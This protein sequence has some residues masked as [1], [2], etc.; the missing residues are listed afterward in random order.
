MRVGLAAAVVAAAGRVEWRS[1]AHVWRSGG[2]R[3]RVM[4]LLRPP[5]LGSMETQYMLCMY[6]GHVSTRNAGGIGSP[7]A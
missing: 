4:A 3:V 1:R 6:M 5:R 7:L 2:R